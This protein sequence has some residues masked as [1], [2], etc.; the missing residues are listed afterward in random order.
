MKYKLSK[1]I[2]DTV[3]SIS[4]IY[5]LKNLGIKIPEKTIWVWSKKIQGWNGN[6]CDPSDY[7]LVPNVEYTSS[8]ERSEDIPTLSGPELLNLLPGEILRDGRSYSL[9]IFK[10]GETLKLRYMKGILGEPLTEVQ[11]ESLLDI[12]YSALLSLYGKD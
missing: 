11:G 3:L 12:C 1:E 10:I 5:D 4:Q 7:S 6:A 8:F 2:I 9:E